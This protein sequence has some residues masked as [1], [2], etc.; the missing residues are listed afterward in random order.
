MSQEGPEKLAELRASIDELDLK[1]VELLNQRVKLAQEVGRTK[2]FSNQVIFVPE[3]E[4]EIL[5]RLTQ[6]NQGPLTPDQLSSVFREIISAAR[7]AEQPLKVAYWGPE[8]SF[9]N[10]AALK[11]FGQSSVAVPV[12]SIEDVFLE[13]QK[14]SVDYG[15]VPV[16]N[17]VGGAVPET[18]DHFVSSPLQICAQTSIPVVHHLVSHAERLEDIR[19]VYAGPQPKAQCRKWLRANLPNAE[20]IDLT[21]TSACVQRTA[22]DHSAAAIATSLAAEIIGVPILRSHLQDRPDNRTRFWVLGKNLPAPT[23]FDRTTIRFGLKNEPGKLYAALGIFAQFE[24]NLLMIESRPSPRD[25]FDY[26]FFL[27]CEGH[28]AQ[29]KLGNAIKALQEICT[30]VTILGS[31]PVTDWS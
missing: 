2:G 13:V 10:Q 1:L 3:R 7:A 20:V 17:S 8:G 6:A 26:I 12:P 31:Y 21:P 29:E 25:P 16:E 9:S 28:Q 24:V 4:R 27:D 11:A 15:I 19:T 30:E 18:L 23:G 14:G 22:N 5:A